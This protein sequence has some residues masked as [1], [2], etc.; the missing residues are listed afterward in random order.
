MQRGC[1]YIIEMVVSII[2]VGIEQAN[3]LEGGN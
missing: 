3:I 2:R 1:D